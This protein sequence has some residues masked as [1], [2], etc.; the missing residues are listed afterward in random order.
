MNRG[1]GR[2]PSRGV[3]GSASP[4]RTCQAGKTVGPLHQGHK[5][6]KLFNRESRPGLFTIRNDFNGRTSARFP[7]SPGKAAKLLVRSL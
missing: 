6:P 4:L 2:S 5:I 3:P 7:F 1:G